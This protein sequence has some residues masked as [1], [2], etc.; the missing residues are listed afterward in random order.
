MNI[1]FDQGTPRPLRDHLHGHN[2][3]I[4][5]ELGW[6]RLTNGELLSRAESAGYEL[7]ITTDGNM[8]SQL[9]L[10]RW[11][12]AV[13]VLRPTDWSVIWTGIPLILE[14]INRCQPGSYQVV[15]IES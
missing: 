15:T 3:A 7:L 1:L 10:S 13:L 8:R 5:R 4:P 11:N 12:I 2:V 9:D 6:S 14:A